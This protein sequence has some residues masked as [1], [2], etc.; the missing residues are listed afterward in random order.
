MEGFAA[1]ATLAPAVLPSAYVLAALSFRPVRVAG[2]QPLAA[3]V[4][5]EIEVKGT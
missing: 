4:L 2:G 1:P 3:V 5:V